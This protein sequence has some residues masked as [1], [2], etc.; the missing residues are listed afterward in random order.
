[1]TPTA[2]IN[3]NQK[4]SWMTITLKFAGHQIEDVLFEENKSYFAV[5]CDSDCIIGIRNLDS[6]TVHQSLENINLWG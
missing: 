3:L 1:M 5:N 4:R 6:T 2:S